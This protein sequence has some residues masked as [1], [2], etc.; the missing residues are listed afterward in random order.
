M[1]VLLIQTPSVDSGSAERVYPVGI[2]ILAGALLEKGF[3][4]ELIDMNIGDDPF[5]RVKECLLSFSPG[6][7]GLSLRN[8]DPLANKT[9]SLFPPFLV[10]AKMAAALLPGSR[11]IAGGTGFS[12]FPERIM[13]EVPELDYGIV[14]E[15]EESFP[16]L[17]R[18]LD[19]PP[20]LKGLCTRKNGNINI[21]P[22]SR[23]VDLG[24]YRTP[25]WDLLDP[26]RYSKIN[27]YVP[28]MGIETKRGCPFHCS[29]CVY[30]ELQGRTLR[31]RPSKSV[32]DEIELLN[33][34]HGVDRFHFTDSIVNFPEDRLEEICR[35][36]IRRKL[37]VRWDGFMREDYF[38][39][40]NA[41]LFEKAGCECFSFSPDGLCQEHLDSLGKRLSEKDVLSA[42][43]I[44]SETDVMSVYHFLVNVPGE[45]EKTAEKGLRLL[46]KIYGFHEVKRNLGTVVLNAIRIL[47]GT[48][49]EATA[50]KNNVIGPETDLLY[51]TYYNPKPFDTFRYRLEAEHL[52]RN[53]FMWHGVRS[54]T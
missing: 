45:T 7:V 34:E 9:T 37:T 30:P 8:I 43:R 14:G 20:D 29:Y 46:E 19:S 47:P 31:C 6:V 50:L 51:P 42:V 40:E 24:N 48:A 10:T 33:K 41:A 28:S 36:I 11:I 17:L 39:A 2:V 38:N 27:S 54:K 32:V 49:I 53:V 18:S 26:A 22:P 52:C 25:R 1:R 12:L 23:E 35:E 5:G 3:E 44:A 13:R 15:A 21:T 16:A 4:V